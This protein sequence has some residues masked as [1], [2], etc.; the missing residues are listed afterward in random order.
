M[1]PMRGI[2]IESMAQAMEV[3]KLMSISGCAVPN[4]LRENPGA[5]LAISIMGYEWGINPFAVANKSYNVNDR[6][7]FEAALYNA[8]ATRRAPIKG[9]IK[10]AYAGEGPT[11]TCLVSAELADGSGSVDYLSP[12]FAAI[13]PKNSPLWKN[14]PDQQLAYFSVRG[15]VRRH[16]PDVMMGIYTVDELIDNPKMGSADPKSTASKLESR[17]GVAQLSEGQTF[18]PDADA[19]ESVV[20]QT[21]P[22]AQTAAGETVDPDTGEISGENASQGEPNTDKPV[23]PEPPVTA[24]LSHEAFWQQIEST[25]SLLNL[26]EAGVRAGVDIAIPSATR[27]KATPARRRQVWLDLCNGVAPFDR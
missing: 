23:I 4:H 14:D 20:A 7:G 25:A 2:V 22:D 8:V 21:A 26:P 3:A 17:L 15:F 10:Y 5:C 18:V 1:S 6:L 24:F 16:F 19:V 13:N 27:N 9:R 11:R 12:K